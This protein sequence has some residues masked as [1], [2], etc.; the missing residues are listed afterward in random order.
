MRRFLFLMTIILASVFALNN[1]GNYKNLT[2]QTEAL[3]RD[4]WKLMEVGGQQVHDSLSSSF[5]FTPG[6]ISGSTGCNWLSAGFI[7]GKH[8]TVTFT[9]DPPTKIECKNENAAKLETSFLDALS[10]STKWD[11]SGGVLSL[12]DGA[13]TLIKLKSL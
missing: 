9:P 8:Q 1:C 6:R 12:G 4:K 2:T 11:I 5:E 7:A 10:K 13:N 3:F